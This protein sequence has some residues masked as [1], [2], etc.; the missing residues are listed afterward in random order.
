MI[1]GG[2]IKTSSPKPDALPG[3]ATPRPHYLYSYYLL[4]QQVKER[5]NDTI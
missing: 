2:T 3:C 4:I 1:N 5:Q